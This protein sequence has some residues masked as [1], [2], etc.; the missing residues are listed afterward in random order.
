MDAM[1]NASEMTLGQW[2][3][4]QIQKAA[5]I[6][7]HFVRSTHHERL[8]WCPSTEEVSKCRSVLDMVGECIDANRR[9][10]W[11]FKSD[12][13]SPR[14]ESFDTSAP[15]DDA[16]AAL[17]S[18]ADEL[19]EIIAKLSNEDLMKDVVTHRGPLPAAMAMQFPVRNMTYHMGQINMIQLLYGDTDFHINEEFITL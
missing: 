7:A 5:R 15:V 19:A 10:V 8:R 3:A 6:Y 13:A 18:S 2:Q 1:V 4:R 11:I 16:L 12:M 17:I 9:F 14:P